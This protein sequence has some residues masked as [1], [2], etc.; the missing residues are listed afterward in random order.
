MAGSDRHIE[1]SFGG[2][3]WCRPDELAAYGP[4]SIIQAV[5]TLL[6]YDSLPNTV[7]ALGPR[8]HQ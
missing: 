4:L 1:H 3:L 7:T 5:N 8:L 2:R 6:D